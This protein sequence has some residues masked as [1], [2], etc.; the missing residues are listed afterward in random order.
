MS[1]LE[2]DLVN[3]VD[4]LIERYPSLVVCKED[5]INSYLLLEECYK[6]SHKLLL[7]GNGG[8]ASD[9]EHIVAELMKNFEIKRPI[10]KKIIDELKSINNEYSK[11]LIDKLEGCLPVISLINHDSLNTALINETDSELIFA[12]QLNAYGNPNDVFLAIS[13]SG[14][15]RNIIY[16]ALLAKAKGLKVIGL[17]GKN[18]SE[19]SKIADVTIKVPEDRTYMIQELHLPIYHTLCLMLECKFFK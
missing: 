1:N 3:Y 4:I 10:D 13:T 9:C 14:N 8:S 5:I 6:N 2:Q 16:A 15:S 12:Q 17:T 7:A 11:T 18:E 19:L